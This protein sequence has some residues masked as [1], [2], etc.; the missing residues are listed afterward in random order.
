M[1]KEL[2][3]LLNLGLEYLLKLKLEK[4]LLTMNT[5]NSG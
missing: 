5:I 1:L 2:I 3:N 4:L